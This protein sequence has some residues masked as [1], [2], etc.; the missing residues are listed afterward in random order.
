[1]VRGTTVVFDKSTDFEKGD[2]GDLKVG[3]TVQAKG[4]LSGGNQL[5]AERIKFFK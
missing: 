4:T 2:L 5:H 3:S 1:V